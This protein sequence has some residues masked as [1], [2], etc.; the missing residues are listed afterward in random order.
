MTILR[1]LGYGRNRLQEIITQ[2]TEELCKLISRKEG[3]IIDIC[4]IIK[5][6]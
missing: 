1:N 2:E 6:V 4:D 5:Y 3:K